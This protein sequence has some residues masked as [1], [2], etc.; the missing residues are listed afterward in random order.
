[1]RARDLARKENI[2]MKILTVPVGH[3]ERIWSREI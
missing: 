3:W 2:G 1:M